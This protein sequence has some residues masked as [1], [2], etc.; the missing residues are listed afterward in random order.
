[1]R[2]NLYITAALFTLFLSGFLLGRAT[3]PTKVWVTCPAFHLDA[4]PPP[5]QKG[6]P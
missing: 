1:M 3:K 4:G 2:H 5:L 6:A